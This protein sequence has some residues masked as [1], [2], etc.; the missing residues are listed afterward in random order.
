MII[1]FFS[2]AVI[3]L[4]ATIR[5]TSASLRTVQFSINCTMLKQIA[6]LPQ[7]TD[8]PLRRCFRILKSVCCFF[9]DFKVLNWSWN[10][11]IRVRYRIQVASP[12][13]FHLHHLCFMIFFFNSYIIF[14]SSSSPLFHYLQLFPFHL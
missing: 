3:A 14:N 8:A 5:P 2:C 7:T 12:F 10:L 9:L 1:F 11:Q 6:P 4:D 13:H